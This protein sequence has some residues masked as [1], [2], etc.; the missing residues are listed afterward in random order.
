M[1]LFYILIFF[2]GGGHEAMWKPWPGI[3]PTLPALESKVLTTGPSGKSLYCLD[4]S[5]FVV[6]F[7]T[8]KC[9]SFSF[10][11]LQGDF[12][13]SGSYALPYEF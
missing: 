13:Y 8:S 9:E 6:S 2:W 1:F 7:E 3:E 4:Y 11:H 5:S 10:V 12:H